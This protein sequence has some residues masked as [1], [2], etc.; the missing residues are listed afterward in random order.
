MDK[1]KKD[2]LK[3]GLLIVFV[4]ASVLLVGLIWA[5]GL[6]PDAP[7]TP[8]YYRGILDVTPDSTL[9]PAGTP[10]PGGTTGPLILPGLDDEDA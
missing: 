7:P 6:V 4:C 10:A 9:V 8:S 5:G 3:Q 1:E 2:R